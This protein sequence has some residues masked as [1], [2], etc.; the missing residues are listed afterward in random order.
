M[1]VSPGLST[2]A[3]RVQEI[4][5]DNE[6]D[7]EISTASTAST[8]PSHPFSFMDLPTE[9]RFMIYRICLARPKPILLYAPSPQPDAAQARNIAQQARRQQAQQ[10]QQAQLAQQQ[11]L[12]S[13]PRTRASNRTDPATPESTNSDP[14]TPALLRVSRTIYA[15]AKRILYNDNTLHIPLRDDTLQSLPQ[16]TRSQLRHARIS[17]HSDR[18]TARSFG[19]AIRLGLRYC[20][21]LQSAT[22]VMPTWWMADPSGKMFAA[23]FHCLFWLPRGCRVVLEGEANE[24]VR[25]VV[26]AR[27]RLAET[28]DEKTWARLPY[29]DR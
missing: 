22:V 16:R 6:A 19:D 11:Q 24:Q 21:G 9:L 20:W 17:Y 15:E 12:Q 27:A 1:S 4:I 14:L 18:E 26:E 29:A 23:D 3:Q 8:D 5:H 2:P 13:Q 7:K 25:A 28:A 10:Q